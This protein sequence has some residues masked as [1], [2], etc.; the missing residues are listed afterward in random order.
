MASIVNDPGGRRRILFVNPEGDRKAIRLGKVSHRSAEG[1]KHRVQQLLECLLLNRPMEADLAQWVADLKPRMDVPCRITR[2]DG[3][4]QEIS[5]LCRIDT[6]N[7]VDYYRHGGIL[8]YVL[9]QLAA[10]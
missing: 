8:H 4:S 2:A 1:L 10:D 7:E 6:E 9:R 5:L 3:S